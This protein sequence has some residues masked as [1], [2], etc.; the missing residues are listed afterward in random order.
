VSDPSNVS[1][2]NIE[3]HYDE[4][5]DR[6]K[7]EAGLDQPEVGHLFRRRKTYSEILGSLLALYIP[8]TSSV[9]SA[10]LSA[11]DGLTYR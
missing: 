6:E 10:G 3:Q 11:V 9:R 5:T 1:K 8:A 2:E 4:R 7:M